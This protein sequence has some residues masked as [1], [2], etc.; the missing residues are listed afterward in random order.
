[1]ADEDDLLSRANSLIHSD[2]GGS[3]GERRRL[4]QTTRR[5]RSF[6]ASLDPGERSSGN[7]RS[8]RG[9]HDD[10]ELPLL[11]DVVAGDDAESAE[12]SQDRAADLRPALSSELA[13]L[14]DRHLAAVLPGLIEAAA[15]V[16]NDQLRR[17][18]TAS[19]AQALDDFVAQRGQLLLPLDEATGDQD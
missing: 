6:L 11:T 9:P 5:R 1:M 17:N 10:E 19:V 12:G 2:A 4:P 8:A 7:T 15:Q 18:L 3:P 14:L 16:A 13:V